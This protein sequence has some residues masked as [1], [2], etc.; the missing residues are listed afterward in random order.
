MLDRDVKEFAELLNAKGVEYLVAGGYALVAHWLDG[1]EFE[2]CFAL[3]EQVELAGVRLNIIGLK[4]S[5][6]TSV[7]Q[8]GSKTWR[9]WK[10]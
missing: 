10:A 1:V 9:M 3:R 7:L 2:A 5:K 4:T 8:V 6:P